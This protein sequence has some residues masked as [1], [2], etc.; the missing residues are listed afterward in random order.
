M[1]P[2]DIEQIERMME[3]VHI[4]TRNQQPDPNA[5]GE[6]DS[7]MN[8]HFVLAGWNDELFD[9]DFLQALDSN[10]GWGPTTID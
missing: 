9:A 4:S 3:D 8:N 1:D 10:D 5:L 7:K 6:E 2:K